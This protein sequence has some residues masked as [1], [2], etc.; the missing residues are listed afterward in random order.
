MVFYDPLPT[1][2]WFII[3]KH[4]HGMYLSEVNRQIHRIRYEVDMTNHEGVND[5]MEGGGI[6]QWTYIEWISFMTA[7]GF[8]I[9]T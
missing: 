8:S 5:F 3:Y 1:E 7:I 6:T 9:H 4:E 2:I